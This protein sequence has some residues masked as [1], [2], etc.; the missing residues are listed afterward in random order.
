MSATRHFSKYTDVRRVLL[1]DFVICKETE[2]NGCASFDS[3]SG[4]L[5]TIRINPNVAALP[6][7]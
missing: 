1:A 2:S 5:E 6:R 4:I 3:I 7:V